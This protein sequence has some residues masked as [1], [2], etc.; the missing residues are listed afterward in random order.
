M[1]TVVGGFEF[2][3]W[4]VAAGLEKASVVEPVDVLEGGDL[5]LLDGPPRSAGFDQFGL[6]QADRGLGQRVV[7]GVADRADRRVDP[8]SARRSV[9]AMDVYCEPA[10]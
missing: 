1:L 4:D 5:D 10:S 7:V 3:G 8:A 6:E 9:K 2:G